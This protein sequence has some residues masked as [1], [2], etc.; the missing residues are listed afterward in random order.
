MGTPK[1]TDTVLGV[2]YEEM[3]DP[4]VKNFSINDIVVLAVEEFGSLTLQ[5]VTDEGDTTTNDI[6]ANSFSTQGAKVWDDGT[7]EGS[8]FQFNSL[9]GSL[10]SAAADNKAWVL[11]DESGIIALTKYKVYTALLTQTGTAAP[12]AVVLEN[13]LGGDIIW[14]Y[15]STGEYLGT[16]TGAFINNKTYFSG[17]ADQGT[18]LKVLRVNNDVVNVGTAISGIKTNGGLN[19]TPIEIRVY[20]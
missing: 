6:T 5:D 10:Q 11:P 3:K 4:A 8:S 18:Q 7:I 15:Q 1:L 16:L 2:Q 14:T 20:N 17:L 19:L 9:L 12:V 13:T